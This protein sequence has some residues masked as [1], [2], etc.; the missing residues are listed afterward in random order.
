M[1]RAWQQAGDQIERTGYRTQARVPC[2][3]DYICSATMNLTW[4]MDGDKLTFMITSFESKDN[5][6][7]P[8]F[9]VGTD[10]EIVGAKFTAI[11]QAPGLIRVDAHDQQWQAGN[12]YYCG[13]GVSTAD[14]A[15]CGA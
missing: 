3:Y 6:G 7:T 9:D 15:K 5:T 12:P 14:K 11:Y 8:E 2:N 4:R 1:D 10:S 13:N